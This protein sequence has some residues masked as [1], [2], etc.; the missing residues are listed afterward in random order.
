MAK[1][2]AAGRKLTIEQWSESKL[3]SLLLDLDLSGRLRA[4]FFNSTILTRDWFEAHLNSV[5]AN[6]GPRYTASLNVQTDLWKWIGGFGRTSSFR[7]IIVKE[8]Y[9]MSKSIRGNC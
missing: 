1:A 3:R 9:L 2:G 4:F 7:R 6:A 5:R 8:N